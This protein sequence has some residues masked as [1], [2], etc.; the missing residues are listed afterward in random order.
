VVER[1]R[2]RLELESAASALPAARLALAYALLGE[3]EKSAAA[4]AAALELA[5]EDEEEKARIDQWKTAV[6]GIGSVPQGERP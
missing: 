5:A 2:W 3:E 1:E 6:E 4:F